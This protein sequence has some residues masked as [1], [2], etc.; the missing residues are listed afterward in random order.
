MNMPFAR[1]SALAALL[2]SVGWL[3]SSP[4]WEP[5]V[6]V[7]TLLGTFIGLDGGFSSTPRVAGR[8]EYVVVTNDKDF[9]HKGDCRIYQHGRHVRMH[10]VRRFTCALKGH[11]RVYKETEAVWASDW[12][13]ICEDNNLR[14]DYHINLPLPEGGGVQIEAMCRLELSSANPEEMTGNYFML[15][16]FDEA[17]LNSPFGTIVF[18]RL[19]DNATLLPPENCTEVQQIISDK[20]S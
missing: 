15:P 11:Q 5:A 16:P 4:S 12:A 14:L 20:K 8:W 6:A 18:R 17:V 3:V 7:V 19:A 9:S 1:Y 10:G 2:G 13:E